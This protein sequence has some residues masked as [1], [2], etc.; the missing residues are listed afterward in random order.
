MGLTNEQIAAQVFSSSEGSGESGDAD[1]S[2]ASL[3]AGSPA[4]SSEEEGGEEASSEESK[5]SV[6]SE[7]GDKKLS[8]A[9]ALKRVPPDVAKLM[10]Q[11][12]ADYT[13]KTQE[14]AQ[15]KKEVLREREALLKGY[16]PPEAKTLPEYDPYNEGSI[17]ARIQAE[18]ERRLAEVLQP[19][20]EEFE[21]L[22]AEAQYNEFLNANPDFE[23][24]EEL[25][26]ETQKI[27]EADDRVDLETAYWAARGRLSV[28]RQKAAS[29]KA[30][31]S[32]EAARKTAQATGLPARPAGTAARPTASDLKSMG[33]ADILAAAQRLAGQ[34]R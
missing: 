23:K 25:R 16:K 27:L 15:T 3:G 31:A 7:G 34:R 17:Q 4:S 24:D 18:V 26:A 14:V 9:D 19:A 1:S 32:R 8:W 12:Q 21:V 29:Q 20:R 11:M 10:K 28:A 33:A 22:Q 30:Q 5:P 2:R 13:K 6:S